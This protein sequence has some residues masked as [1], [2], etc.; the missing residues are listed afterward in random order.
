MSILKLRYLN[1]FGGFM[2]S[3]SGPET[4]QNYKSKCVYLLSLIRMHN[5]KI[6]ESLSE[7]FKNVDVDESFEFYNKLVETYK[8]LKEGKTPSVSKEKKAKKAEKPKAQKKK[9]TKKAEKKETK[10]KASKKK[11]EK[12]EDKE[13]DK[14]SKKKTAKKKAKK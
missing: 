5:K 11:T 14:K 6:H 2:T 12:K 3:F 10:K 7:E 13:D 4:S 8:A 1:I 9:V